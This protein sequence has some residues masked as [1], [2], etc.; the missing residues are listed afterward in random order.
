MVAA[1]FPSTAAASRRFALR[2]HRNPLSN[3]LGINLSWV[4][5]LQGNAFQMDF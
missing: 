2:I 5:D 4:F 1:R 3:S